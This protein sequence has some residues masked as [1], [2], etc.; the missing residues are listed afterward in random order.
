MKAVSALVSVLKLDPHLR[1]PQIRQ[2]LT[3]CVSDDQPINVQYM[4]NFRRRC[5]FFRAKNSNAT[6]VIQVEGNIIITIYRMKQS[7]IYLFRYSCIFRNMYKNVLPNSSNVWKELAYLR[8][9]KETISGFDYRVNYN[10]EGLP[11]DIVWMTFNMRN[12]LLQYGEMVVL[13]Y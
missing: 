8:S 5:D 1:A 6:E 9:T 10:N 2:L 12:N 7:E 11:D 3:N 4:T 13:D